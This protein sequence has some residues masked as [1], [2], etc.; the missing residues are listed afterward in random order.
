MLASSPAADLARPPY[1]Q[2]DAIVKVMDGLAILNRIVVPKGDLNA[3]RWRGQRGHYEA[4]YL[5]F[6]ARPDR[7]GFWLRYTVNTP[8]GAPGYC[9]LWAHVFDATDPARTFGIRQRSGLTGM[10]RREGALIRIGEASLEEGR[11]LGRVTSHG[12]SV[13]W[14]VSFDSDP[15]AVH[16]APRLVRALGLGSTHVVF[17]NSDARLRGVVKVDG[18]RAAITREPGGQTHLWGTKHAERW[19]WGHC[20]AFEGRD[21]CALD[22]VATFLSSRTCSRRPF[23]A[24]FVRY[25]GSDYCLNALPQVLRNRSEIDFPEWR[26][27]GSARG[28]R[29]VGSFRS[30]RE[31]MV[32]V[33][34]DDPDG[35]RSYCANTEI[36][37]LVLEIWRGRHLSD[38]LHASGTAHLEF[39]DRQPLGGVRATV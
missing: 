14:D 30:A 26:F 6:N 16:L 25:G 37:D 17:A 8:L 36:G 28:L 15:C 35:E 5:T 33:T 11:A 29:F 23:T 24:V 2:D 9:E 10:V 20:N 22:A 21:D 31:R 38:R 18:R 32:Q 19:V 4:W 39:G 27:Q 1:A 13:E 3:M 34:Y 7:L 12:H